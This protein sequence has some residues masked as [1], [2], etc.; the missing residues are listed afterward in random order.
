[1]EAED[2]G[3][4]EPPFRDGGP[5]VATAQPVVLKASE[6]VE[7][8]EI[9]PEI[10]EVIDPGNGMSPSGGR[11]QDSVQEEA[12]DSASVG[13]NM[14]DDS[15]KDSVLG[16]NEEGVA[17]SEDA[18]SEGAE[19]E[20]TEIEGA[21]TEDAKRPSWKTRFEDV[22]RPSR[23]M[24]QLVKLVEDEAEDVHV[25]DFG[26]ILQLSQWS[27]RHRIKVCQVLQNPSNR[28]I[29]SP[30]CRHAYAKQSL[31]LIK[32]ESLASIKKESLALIEEQSLALIHLESNN[33]ESEYLWRRDLLKGERLQRLHER[34]ADLVFKEWTIL[35]GYLEAELQ[36][37][38]EEDKEKEWYTT[39]DAAF[40]CEGS[41]RPEDIYL[42]VEEGKVGKDESMMQMINCWDEIRPQEYQGATPWHWAALHLKD[43]PQY[44]ELFL[45][46]HVLIEGHR[47]LRSPQIL[48]VLACDNFGFEILHMAIFASSW[49]PYVHP[50]GYH[51]Q[52]KTAI[53]SCLH[54]IDLTTGSP[55]RD[56]DDEEKADGTYTSAA[57]EF[58]I[59]KLGPYY[60]VRSCFGIKIDSHAP[61]PFLHLAIG[62]GHPHVIRMLIPILS[63]QRFSKSG[64]EG[65]GIFDKR[66]SCGDSILHLGAWSM[67]PSFLH[68]YPT[69]QRVM[70]ILLRNLHHYP[71]LLNL[72]NEV[73]QRPLHIATLQGS[74][75][76]VTALLRCPYIMENVQNDYEFTP[77]D[78]LR[79][80]LDSYKMGQKEQNKM[81][82]RERDINKKFGFSSSKYNDVGIS[83]QHMDEHMV[84]DTSTQYTYIDKLIK[85]FEPELCRWKLLHSSQW[86]LRH[87]V[88]TLQMLSEN[89][90]TFGNKTE[91]YVQQ[92]LDIILAMF[93]HSFEESMGARPQIQH[94][95]TILRSCVVQIERGIMEEIF[96][97]IEE[98]DLED[99]VHLM[100]IRRR[101]LMERKQLGKVRLVHKGA[102]PLHWAAFYGRTRMVFFIKEYMQYFDN[103]NGCDNFGFTPLHLAVFSSPH[104]LSYTED[105]KYRILEWYS[106]EALID[107]LYEM[108]VL[109]T[110]S[111]TSQSKFLVWNWGP[112]GIYVDDHLSNS[113]LYP[114]FLGVHFSHPLMVEKLLKRS[115]G[116]NFTKNIML[117]GDSILHCARAWE[118][119]I[120]YSSEDEWRKIESV[121]FI[122]LEIIPKV[123][124]SRN[125]NRETPLH[126][127]VRTKCLKWM[128]VLLQTEH[129]K[130]TSRDRVIL[131]P[132]GL[133]AKMLKDVREDAAKKMKDLSE[134]APKM[135][136]DISEDAAKKMK[137]LSEVAAKMLKDSSE[138]ATKMLKGSIENAAKKLKDSIEDAAKMLK[139]SSD[140]AAKKLKDFSL[141]SAAKM[142]K[143]C[144][145]AAKK[146]KESSE[147]AKDIQNII[148]LIDSFDPESVPRREKEEKQKAREEKK[149]RENELEKMRRNEAN[150]TKMKREEREEKEKKEEEVR[151]KIEALQR[152]RQVYVD[153][154]NAILV[155]A[156]LVASASFG[157]WLQPPLGFHP[158]YSPEFLDT[159]APPPVGPVY[160]SFVAIQQYQIIHAFWVFNSLSFFFSL[161]TVIAGADAALPKPG[162][163]SG[164]SEQDVKNALN[165]VKKAVKLAAWLL[166][167][168]IIF[169]IC[170]FA[171]LGFTVLPPI[172]KYR[173]NL[174]VTVVVG[175][176]VCIG[177]LIKLGRKL[178]S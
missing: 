159:T 15:I 109:D 79:D 131:T 133:A 65:N 58:F 72:G 51:D 141:G 35:A 173:I 93:G 16:S 86:S 101:V 22:E 17:A 23:M 122:H 55:E 83:G 121:L 80:I 91:S 2:A 31:S 68:D 9:S 174:I 158:Y 135:L 30:L 164:T 70:A 87:R 59:F 103:D 168:A 156:A 162:Y 77:S 99:F 43:F 66:T 76:C 49:I 161:A 113:D 19:M 7:V 104:R 25:K 89:S 97:A 138:D 18:G 166:I 98:D 153:A 129:V 124:N 60:P 118:G 75:E 149:D 140:D 155:G 53:D 177:F 110:A 33:T 45:N 176:L 39:I 90:S 123:V 47:I 148:D 120:K 34:V 172:A 85:E 21:A 74:V 71:T 1:M 54:I 6:E 84:I 175:G 36:S 62:I 160:E 3:Y 67:D 115:V 107:K 147:D 102:T 8:S 117:A 92:C 178:V 78:I 11:A 114:I 37:L 26:Q 167:L 63:D 13:S 126:I 111:S 29:M 38:R 96:C 108:G 171:T 170:T 150:Q 163:G 95:I 119:L 157:A 88:L 127:A 146:L 94:I 143:D 64:G 73:G 100:N 116:Q 5:E 151:K 130:F 20:G 82:G 24:R 46:M 69:H 134:D 40:Q 14:K 139:D 128:E 144:S 112:N 42:A 105:N 145:D 154:A 10:I 50:R 48:N 142:L 165:S 125:F 52:D 137:D 136:E 81:L 41:F 28:W 61:I 4:S 44:K 12:G 32:N 106:W 56:N 152:D 57:P 169:V 27:L 132:G